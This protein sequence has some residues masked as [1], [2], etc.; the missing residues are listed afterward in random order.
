MFTSSTKSLCL[1]QSSSEKSSSD[2]STC[3][4]KC[5][6]QPGSN[7]YPNYNFWPSQ[8]DLRILQQNN[9]LSNPMDKDFDYVKEFNSLNLTAVKQDLANVMITSQDW[10]P[11]DF[12]NY[13][14]FIVRMAWHSARTYRS[15]DGRGGAGS[16]GLRFAP[17]N[18]WPDNANLDKARRLI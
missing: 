7:I 18:S 16:G 17:L 14:P 9:P 12:G 5:T 10:W 2:K 4:V 15:G 6:V 1:F 3:P 11:A 13:G 8:I